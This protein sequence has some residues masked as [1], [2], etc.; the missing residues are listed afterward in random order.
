MASSLTRRTLGVALSI[1]AGSITAGLFAASALA[2]PVT[3][4]DLLHAQ[5]NGAEWLM[6]GRDYL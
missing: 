2:A 5:D 4:E 1:T 6:Y 3:T